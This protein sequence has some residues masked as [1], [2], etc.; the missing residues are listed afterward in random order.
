M[1]F[2]TPEGV[3]E[4]TQAMAEAG[5]HPQEEIV[6]DGKIHRFAVSKKGHKDGWYVFYGMA[7][8]FGD[9]SQGFSKTWSAN[10]YSLSYEGKNKVKQQIE[11]VKKTNGGRRKSQKAR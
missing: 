5:L 8:A 4:F 9:W 10:N 2:S 7:G 3:R 1:I 11:Q 6:P